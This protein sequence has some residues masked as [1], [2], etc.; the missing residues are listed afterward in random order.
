MNPSA[1]RFTRSIELKD[2]LI[3]F[4]VIFYPIKKFSVVHANTFKIGR[5]SLGM[6]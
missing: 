3:W 6:L 2:E 1:I 5:L 4:K